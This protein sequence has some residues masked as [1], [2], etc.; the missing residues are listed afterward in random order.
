VF[1]CPPDRRPHF[2]HFL[3]CSLFLLLTKFQP[4]DDNSDPDGV[5][6]WVAKIFAIDQREGRPTEPLL[7]V[8]YYTAGNGV[9]P[10]Y[11]INMDKAYTCEVGTVLIDNF[12]FTRAN[13]IPKNIR[14]TAETI[15][16][17]RSNQARQAAAAEAGDIHD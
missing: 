1:T 2:K 10:T 14:Q 16:R 4:A 9:N 5:E 3:Y 6:L 8:H 13:K 11:T 15:S 12:L 7:H 17:Q